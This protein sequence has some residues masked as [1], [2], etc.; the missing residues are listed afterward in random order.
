MAGHAGG[1]G[2]P[3]CL[4]GDAAGVASGQRSPGALDCLIVSCAACATAPLSGG[5]DGEERGGSGWGCLR[6]DGEVGI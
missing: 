5:R 3:C 1:K 6:V 4:A 2:L